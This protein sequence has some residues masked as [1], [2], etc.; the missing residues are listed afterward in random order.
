MKKSKLLAI[1][2]A[3]TLMFGSMPGA[4]LYADSIGKEAQACKELGVLI[5]R[6]ASGVTAEYLTETPT[7]IQAFIIFLRLKG[8]YQDA[9]GYTGSGNFKDAAM[10]GWAQNY[11]AYAKSK[12]ELGWVGDGTNFKPSDPIT[13]QQYYKVMLETLGYRQGID[14]TYAETLKFAQKIGLVKSADEIAKVK[15]FTIDDV[16][17]GIYNTLNTKSQGSSKKLISVMVDSKIITAD[18]AV[19]AGFTLDTESAK[20]LSFKAVANN[21]LELEFDRNINL[22][23]GDIEINRMNGSGRLSVLSVSVQKNKASIITTEAKPFNAY[24]A[25]INTLIPTENMVIRDYKAKYVAQPRDVV[26]PTAK[27]EL[28]SNNEI[29]LNFSE[30]VEKA[31]AEDLSNYYIE[32]NVVI[33]NAELQENNK[34]VLLKTTDMSPNSFYR[35]TVQNVTDISGNTMEKYASLF[36]GV[37]SDSQAPSIV[38]VQS[39]NSSTVS[40]TFNERVDAATAENTNNYSIDNNIYV[41]DARLDGSRKTVRLTTSLQKSGTIYNLT[42]QNVAD[43]SGNIMNRKEWRLVGDTSKPSVTV[44]A[45]SN[46]EVAVNFNEKVDKATAEDITNYSIDKGLEVKKAV[47]DSTRKTVTLITSSQTARELYTVNVM[48]I[49]D[50][51]GNIMN[52]YTG[53]FGGM[54]A[55]SKELSYTVKGGAS[56]IIVTFNKSVDKESAEDVF[57]YTLDSSLGYAAKATLDDSGRTVTLLTADQTSGKMYTI[58]VNNIKDLT[59]IKIS[60]DEKVSTKKFIGVSASGSSQVT[61]ILETIVT[62]DFNTIDLLFSDELSADELASMKAAVSVPSDA[63]YSLPEGLEYSKFYIGGKKNVRLQ[64]KTGSSNNPDVFRSGRI[65]EIKIT[66]IDRLNSKDDANVKPFAG[67]GNQNEAP[68]V[69]EVTPL[70]ST[71]V[72]VRFSEPVK[73]L[74]KYQFDIKSSVTISDVSVSSDEITESVILYLSNSTQLKDDT[75]YKL[76]VKTGIKDAAG[77]AAVEGAGSSSSYTEFDGTSEKNQAPVV[78]SGVNILDKYTLQLAFNEPIRSISSSSFSIKKVSGSSS[79]SYVISKAILSEDK[80]MVTLYYNSR[81]TGFVDGSE[82]EL[83]IGSSVTDL[84]GLAID[85]DGR[86]HEF[87]GTDSEPEK[88]EIIAAQIDE[89]NEIITLSFN[90]AIVAG[91]LSMSD[92]DI[93]GAG[94]DDSSSDKVEAGEKT[95]KITLRNQLDS[96]EDFILT[97]KDSGRGKI[98]DYNGQQLDTTRVEMTTR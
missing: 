64:Y 18:K 70:N 13:A 31:G 79:G 24:E 71:A 98:K 36:E 65:Y 21:K 46:N 35:L 25:T 68:K 83:S 90:K 62:V 80:K 74:T 2:L 30:E 38:S 49:S 5:G 94:Y 81:Y 29:M 66:G 51:W 9:T 48:N 97:I 8:L 4:V 52:L 56:S 22:Q 28:L 19:A 88:P 60:S 42:V 92:F 12:P 87:V 93:S 84:Q 33:L 95:V 44:M 45:V 82:Y 16:A 59:G 32:H 26:R 89:N 15:S 73:G 67:T 43:V 63:S 37:K 7:R 14:F 76:Y 85:A 40:I 91:D 78:E 17:K 69:I 41:S 1:L 10:A 50:L 54:Q 27:H 55:V 61:L 53:K 75:T 11:M 6:D 34:S 96:N 57:N 39:E 3:F 23:K 20:V 77:Y 58:S 47:L 86:K 72:E